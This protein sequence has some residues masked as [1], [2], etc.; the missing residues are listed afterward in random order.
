M[1]V[2]RDLAA[3]ADAQLSE[4][5][6]Y[7]PKAF[8]KALHLVWRAARHWGLDKTGIRRLLGRPGEERLQG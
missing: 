5:E 8:R 4:G 7:P 1:S 3:A 2:C 6:S